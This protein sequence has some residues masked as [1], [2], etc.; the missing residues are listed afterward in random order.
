[1]PSPDILQE[2]A[3]FLRALARSLVIDEAR[4][5]D[6]FQQTMLAALERPPR[7]GGNLRGWLGKV[8]RNFAFRSRRSEKRLHGR[9]EH[10][11]KRET[12]ASPEEVASRLEVQR[13]VAEAVHALKEPYRSTIVHR[14]FDDLSADE[15]ARATDTPVATVRTR[16]RR[17][18][19]QVRTRLDTEHGG[20][21]RTWCLALAPLLGLADLLPHLDGKT[22]A[23]AAAGAGSGALVGGGL[24]SG[25]GLIVAAGLALASAAYLLWPAAQDE[26]LPPRAAVASP[27]AGAATTA[28]GGSTP[29]SGGAR[30][31]T[32]AA[33]RTKP[34]AFTVERVVLDEQAQ[35]IAGAAV[36]RGSMPAEA[37]TDEEGRFAV[38]VNSPEVFSVH[39]HGYIAWRG[40]L[41][42]SG[43]ATPITLRRGAA[44]TVL[45]VD[46]SGTPVA[47]AA[48]KASVQSREGVPGMWSYVREEPFADMKTNEAGRA[49]LDSPPGPQV[50]FSVVHA[51]FA[52]SESELLVHG[53]EPIEHEIVLGK[54][55]VIEGHVLDPQGEPLEGAH[56]HVERYRERTTLSGPDGSYRLEG[57]AV[58]KHEVAALKAGYGAGEFGKSIGW[59]NAVPVD[60]RLGRVVTGI[61]IML[62]R[63]IFVTGRVLD[64]DDRPVAGVKVSG[65]TYRSPGGTMTA[66]TGRD[67][68]FRVGPFR[69]SDRDYFQITYEG[70][71]L[72]LPTTRNFVNT[73]EGVDVGDIHA[74]RGGTVRGRV[75]Q[76]DGTPLHSGR[77]YLQ[78][79]RAP[80]ASSRISQS[81]PVRKNGTFEFKGI[82]ATEIH[83]SAVGASKERSFRV[84]VEVPRGGV[85][86]DIE[87]QLLPTIEIGGR[88]TT[89]GG[90]PRGGVQVKVALHEHHGELAAFG[91]R[92]GSKPS[93]HAGGRRW[94]LGLCVGT[95]RLDRLE[96]RLAVGQPLNAEVLQI[97]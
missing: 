16:L 55:G 9:E 64:D 69:D 87:L 47:E 42:P 51:D 62:S 22:G 25:Q 82:A 63:P 58:G 75:L 39:K 81:Q 31:A 33:T 89:P 30:G 53:L 59:A 36:Q 41:D 19:D 5:D 24:T 28:T 50:L 79:G 35:P 96:D 73:A 92:L 57:V 54:G 3:G 84:P 90:K 83:L 56:V 1:M 43:E 93:A 26:E 11:A 86:E 34:A 37:A 27:G 74:T 7:H 29:A 44:L 70:P 20:D 10:A 97:F 8:A 23:T 4:A 77:V 61:D 32:G 95:H 40:T 13:Q 72:I 68:R 66:V 45:V 88:V 80:T 52:P 94:S 67:G 18:L 2:H 15:I 49:E 85:V 6:V 71:G 65:R 78:P 60:V 91:A 48:V 38:G 12:V 17:A 76:A 46:G 14:F 21:R